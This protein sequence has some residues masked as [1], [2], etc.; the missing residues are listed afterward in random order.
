[1]VQEVFV[2]LMIPAYDE[3]LAVLNNI[4]QSI[5]IKTILVKTTNQVT[6]IILHNN[7]SNHGTTNIHM[8]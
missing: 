2:H 3:P 7:L 5:K 4:I 1:M 8:N 6:F